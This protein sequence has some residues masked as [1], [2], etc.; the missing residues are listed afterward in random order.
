MA[1][2]GDELAA[3][4]AELKA[5]ETSSTTSAPLP[6][7]PRAPKVISAAPMRAA[8]PSNLAAVGGA[9]LPPSQWATPEQITSAM[10]SEGLVVPRAD[11]GSAP[12]KP[13]SDAAF[14][15]AAVFEGAKPGYAFKAGAKGVGYY[16]DSGMAANLPPTRPAAF[17]T[18]RAAPPPSSSGARASSSST[19]SHAP[20]AAEK[21]ER[22]VLRTVAGETW[23]DETLLEWPEDDFRVFIGDLG[24]EV[25]DD[26]LAHAFQKCAL[27]HSPQPP[28]SGPVP[29][30]M[31]I[32]VP[33]AKPDHVTVAVAGLVVRALY[34]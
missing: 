5:L 8:A 19:L 25:N 21:R 14:I 16:L 17:D 33:M 32:S 15:A 27:S 1:D 29:S 7:G 2:L 10:R 4:D 6:T 30:A 3:F 26:V 24:N 31:L 34:C 12:S 28:V 22:S 18:S 23:K 11:A 9:R 13:P 20:P